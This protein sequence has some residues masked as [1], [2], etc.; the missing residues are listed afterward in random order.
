MFSF[1]VRKEEHC[2]LISLACVGSARSVSASLGLPPLTVCV[3]YLSTLLRLQVSLQGKFLRQA[4]GFVYFPVLTC[5]GSG[6][7]V[8][9]RGT[10]SV[11]PAFCALPRSEQLR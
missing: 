5:S 3:L 7:Q 10:D 1:A 2:K 4:L 11:G 6:T 9:L 8:V